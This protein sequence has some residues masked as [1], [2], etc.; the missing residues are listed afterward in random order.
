MTGTPH[1]AVDALFGE[2]ADF[3]VKNFGTSSKFLDMRV[4]YSNENDYYLDEEAAI[5]E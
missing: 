3:V 5:T 2:L 1:D 4:E